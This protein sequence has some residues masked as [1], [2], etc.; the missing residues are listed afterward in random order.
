MMSELTNVL[1]KSGHLLIDLFPYVAVGVLAAEILKYTP[2]T[3]FVKQAISRSP[4][5]AVLSATIL[6]IISPLCTYGTIPIVISLYRQGV[7]LAPLLTFLSAS[8]LMNPQLFIITWGG[9][10]AGVAVTRLVSIAVFSLLLGFSI[11]VIEK[12]Y[13]TKPAARVHKKFTRTISTEKS[14]NEFRF[15]KFFSNCTSTFEYIGFYIVTG[16]VISAALETFLPVSL[17]LKRGNGFEWVNILVAS[18]ISIPMY[19]CGGGIIP[20]VDMMMENGMSVGAVMAFLVVGPATRVTPLLALGSFL[21]KKMLSSYVAVLII[22]SF[23]L[24]LLLNMVLK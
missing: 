19:V 2:W 10:G 16:V 6:G 14:W 11:S 21:S 5:I 8:S 3:R 1:V 9:L 20:V 7:F 18:V 17:L 22:Y 23:V 24:G 13:R 12:K 15:R 4:A